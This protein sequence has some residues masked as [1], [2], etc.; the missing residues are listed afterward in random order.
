MKLSTILTNLAIRVIEEVV[1]SDDK[2]TYD[3]EKLEEVIYETI[4]DIE[5]AIEEFWS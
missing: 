1:E 2:L 5:T 3:Y 4:Y